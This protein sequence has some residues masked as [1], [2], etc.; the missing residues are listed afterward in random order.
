MD[1]QENSAEHAISEHIATAK[2]R[3]TSLFEFVREWDAKNTAITTRWTQ[4][5]WHLSFLE[6]PQYP[7]IQSLLGA[8]D[9]D[10]DVVLRVKRPDETPCPR[11]PEAVLP[12]L[13]GGWKDPFREAEHVR[14]L[15]HRV[16]AGNKTIRFEEADE[17]RVAW[18]EWSLERLAWCTGDRTDERPCPPPP[19]ILEPWIDG[20]W[21][22]PLRE[23]EPKEELVR[24][25]EAH[26]VTE[27]FGDSDPR[28][29]AWEQWTLARQ[30]WCEAERPVRKAMGLYDRLFELR[31][32][33][34]R[35]G[36]AYRLLLGDGMVRGPGER[37]EV[38]H[39]IFLQGAEL[40]L[41]E[42][43]ACFTVLLVDEPAF[44]YVEGLATVVGVERGFLGELRD[45]VRSEGIDMRSG[46][47]VRTFMHKALNTLL[48]GVRIADG[49]SPSE[50]DGKVV[51]WREPVLM[52]APR[53]TRIAEA[54]DKIINRIETSPTLPATLMGIVSTIDEDEVV[55]EPSHAG[56]SSGGR[57]TRTVR[58]APDPPAGRG[59]VRRS[60]LLA[61]E[62]NEA[63]E[64]ILMQIEKRDTV[65]VQGPPGTGKTH[66]IANIM[67]H[68]LAKGQRV[69]VVSHASKALRVLRHNL[70]EPLR[71]LCVSLLDSDQ[72]SKDE[73]EQS[74]R[75]IIHR[76]TTDD[77]HES[78][79]RQRELERDRNRLID[80]LEAAETELRNAVADEYR[81]ITVAGRSI[82][83]IKAAKILASQS[84]EERWIPGPL[85]P[86]RAC[87]LTPQEVG[88][89]YEANA[90]V[91]PDHEEGLRGTLPQIDDLP[92]P[93]QLGK[94]LAR[95]DKLKGRNLEPMKG[96]WKPDATTD[97]ARLLDA[98]EHFVKA[99]KSVGEMR[100][101]DHLLEC[102]DAGW[103]GGSQHDAWR[104][105]V[106]MLR[107]KGGQID[108]C[109]GRAMKG[110]AQVPSELATEKGLETCRE[111]RTA[112]GRSGTV[113]KFAFRATARIRPGWKRFLE[114]ATV[115]ERPPQSEA[116]FEAIEARILVSVHRDELQR[117]WRAHFLDHPDLHG[118]DLG[119]K[120]EDTV[121]QH[122]SRMEDAL[123][124]YE[125][126]GRAAL[127]GLGHAGM[128]LEAAKRKVEP[129]SGR[130]AE[131]EHLFEAA[132]TVMEVHT[133]RRLD[134]LELAVVGSRLSDAVAR[135][136]RIGPEHD[137][138]GVSG[139]MAEAIDRAD[140]TGYARAYQY[141][142]ELQQVAPLVRTRAAL[143]TRLRPLAAAWARAIED[144]EP[145]HGGPTTPGDAAEAW[146][147]VL[148]AQELD[149][150]STID[151]S[152]LQARVASLKKNLQEKTAELAETMAWNRQ[153]DRVGHAHRR[154]LESWYNAVSAR[155]FE[156][157]VRSVQLKAQAQR[158]MGE[159]RHAVPAWV[160]TLNRAIETLDFGGEPF[161]VVIVD[162]ASQANM[163]GLL[164]LS[165]A[166][167]AIVVGDDKQV[168]PA[169]VSEELG[170][171]QR[172][173]EQYLHDFS[174]RDHFTGRFSLYHIAKQSFQQHHML[175]EHFRCDAD[176]IAFSNTLSYDGQIE[177][178]RD[179]TGNKIVP[180]T[181][182]HKVHGRNDRKVNREEAEE[183][184]ALIVAC[185]EQPE[186]AGA[187]YGVISMLGDEQALEIDHMV[188]QRL[189]E[190][191]YEKARVLC[192]S[193]AQFQGDER[194][195]IFLSLVHSSGEGP[196]RL[197][198]D[199]DAQKRYNV[200]ASR[201][202]DQLWV[203]HSID[204]HDL[205]NPEDLRRRLLGHVRDPGASARQME[206]IQRKADSPFE[207]AV[208]KELTDRGFRIE[209]QR[210]V[211]A[212]R[213]DLVA[214]G[215]NGR[216]VA[217]ECDGE[218]YHTLENLD[219]DLARQA[220][221]ER[222]GWIFIR[223]GGGAFYRKPKTTIAGLLERLRELGIE[224]IGPRDEDGA[225]RRGEELLGRIRARASAL[226]EQWRREAEGESED[227]ESEDGP[228]SVR[229]ETVGSR[230]PAP[231]TRQ[232]ADPPPE[233]T[234]AAIVDCL[235]QAGRPLSKSEIIRRSGI[236]P[237]HWNRVIGELLEQRT[238]VRMGEKR[239]T[240]Y[241]L[242][243]TDRGEPNGY[244]QTSPQDRGSPEP[245]RSAPANH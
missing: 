69:L 70:P 55:T 119:T 159:A 86:G 56:A 148:A 66:T 81:D 184:T 141:L 233:G 238:I 27:A 30:Q 195:V 16:E 215:A 53:R 87:P 54:V 103:R 32:R 241:R 240:R 36:E 239:G 170:D 60:L 176:I 168:T 12:W 150:R 113:Y 122:A 67:G 9:Q 29:A 35:E 125:D 93:E 218:K 234:H 14:S 163:M 1:T 164:P 92:T 242:P 146:F 185:I 111:M 201:A 62:A 42:K 21:H 243:E 147:W 102:I 204:D 61:K 222:L 96:L 223:I 31:S 3:L 130:F 143:L 41:D 68:F 183:I 8:D 208:A 34:R 191:A 181:V 142:Q 88:Q 109:A 49:P 149:R 230:R 17:R 213:I 76:I 135:L 229:G 186:Y 65:V 47:E 89:L 77:A 40:L 10:P 51:A 95:R 129:K 165:L 38:H 84:P 2:K 221:L 231:F 227:D 79:R 78:Q 206:R 121:R 202:Q 166:R 224:P 108:Q 210:K 64:R 154:A 177:P 190:D 220:V 192:G 207:I 33:L 43:S 140:G 5:P 156:K 22:D 173:I 115:A 209:A 110:A 57:A 11:P 101:R 127:D 37:G 73:L 24:W 72:E 226:R 228:G 4:T 134:A 83:P 132:K 236:D 26:T 171:T 82:A 196:L 120:P 71:P 138:S 97:R 6:L 136:R 158:S 219:A 99:F 216:Q 194:K 25:V 126:L 74:V 100:A 107:E 133:K 58:R 117:H 7:T 124:W 145:P 197:L 244:A 94:D 112:I 172:L 91:R 187:T 169:A 182:E 19:P 162:E 18:D 205:P 237:N 123:R 118:A 52:L 13:L 155:G 114:Q 161:D 198:R 211:G 212:R 153:R 104:S 189:P 85:E 225:P 28:V 245:D 48:R 200:A 90:R 235:A 80:D 174:E 63:Q 45:G 98:W 105:F 180:P 23:V 44:L 175:K 193:A 137:T 151:A 59:E 217:I 75:G 179:T 214:I 15:N 128:D 188:R 131:F 144:R 139:A 152:S 50:P 203:V 157:G 178:I 46:P 116:H 160:M 199:D 20:D 167:K 232:E 39:P 106:A